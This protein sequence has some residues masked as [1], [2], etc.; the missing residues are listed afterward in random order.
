VNEKCILNTVY[1]VRN[2]AGCKARDGQEIVCRKE[3]S[4]NEGLRDKEIRS[5]METETEPQINAC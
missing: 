3:Q 4:R 1:Q 5:W 2:G